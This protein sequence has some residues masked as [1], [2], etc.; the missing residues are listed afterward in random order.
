MRNKAGDSE[1]P[2]LYFEKMKMAFLMVTTPGLWIIGGDGIRDSDTVETH[3][4]EVHLDGFIIEAGLV[5][6]SG[7]AYWVTR[8]REN[9]AEPSILST[10]TWD[11]AQNEF[12]GQ[13]QGSDGSVGKY[14]FCK[15]DGG[16]RPVYSAPDSNRDDMREVMC[17]LPASTM[18][19]GV[20]S[21]DTTDDKTNIEHGTTWQL[22]PP[23]VLLADGL[24]RE[25]KR[26]HLH[27][28]HHHL[29]HDKLPE[30]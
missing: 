2:D 30:V 19:A 8:F 5:S 6:K 16:E 25:Q 26:R 4:E 7:K 29:G 22:D 14:L 27:H 13:W 12:T 15:L 10:G 3:E 20:D 17:T 24:T 9:P 23:S 1:A 11:F 21:D 18:P 28:H